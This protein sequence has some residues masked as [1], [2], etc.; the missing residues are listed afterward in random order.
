[1]AYS[2]ACQQV[3]S[4]RQ[5]GCQQHS[6]AAAWAEGSAVPNFAFHIWTQHSCHSIIADKISVP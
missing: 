4:T 5:Q 1:M 6:T 2:R 3:M